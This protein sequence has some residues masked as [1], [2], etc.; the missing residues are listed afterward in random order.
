MRVV[1]NAGIV[2]VAIACGLTLWW[3]LDRRGGID[4]LAA[5]GITPDQQID[6]V[7]YI[8]D[9]GGV[10]L[11]VPEHA[12]PSPP[13]ETPPL[14]TYTLRTSDHPRLV[15][16]VVHALRHCRTSPESYTLADASVIVV[17]A[18]DGGRA[19]IP[20]ARA[21][22]ARKTTAYIHN[23]RYRSDELGTALSEIVRRRL[24]FSMRQWP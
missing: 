19:A 7:D 10:L 9:L 3:A 20:V 12:P 14:A 16:Q 21:E 1:T 18:K 6:Q 8:A 4:L 15:R 5:A 24:G 13:S 11:M 17:T 2:A 23:A 22:T